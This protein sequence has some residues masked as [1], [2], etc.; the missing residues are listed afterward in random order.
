MRKNES[1]KAF[2]ED[3]GMVGTFEAR[4]LRVSVGGKEIIKGMSIVVRPGEVHAL[5]GPNGSGKST[6]AYALMGHPRYAVTGGTLTIDGE[7]ITRLSPDERAKKGVFLSFQHPVEIPGVT[8]ESFLRMAYNSV[9]GLSL[10]VVEFHRL[11]KERMELLRIDPMF[12]RRYLN[13]GFSGGEKKRME[14]L[15]MLMLDPAFAVLDEA[16]SGL[17]V[18]ALRVVAEGINRMRDPHH[19]IV[20]ITHFNRILKLIEPDYVHV[21][22][23]GRIVRSGGKELAH[24]IE[25]RGYGGADGN[26]SPR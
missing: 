7:D 10:G 23:D 12:A 17:D 19:G 22:A 3:D 13:D 15:Q 25:E 6:L 18:D 20:I 21:I 4:D 14:T 2:G 5:M 9:K 11:L 8:V 1:G 26:D 16:D 24:E